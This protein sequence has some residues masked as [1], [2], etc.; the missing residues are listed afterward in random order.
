MRL[1]ADMVV[2]SACNTA[3]PDGK[4]AGEAFSGLARAFFFAGTRGLIATHWAVADESTALMMLNTVLAVADGQPGPQALRAQQL[5]M[6]TDAGS[7][8]VP[9][10][11]AHPFYWGPF[12]FA[13]TAVA[14]RRNS[15]RLLQAAGQAC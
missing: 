11:W 13:G 8:E 10:R 14:G 7:G 15:R 9:A 1:N 3:G 12:V 2:L 5:G 6:I 4:G